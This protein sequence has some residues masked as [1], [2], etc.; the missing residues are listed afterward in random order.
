MATLAAVWERSEAPKAPESPETDVPEAPK[1]PETASKASAAAEAAKSEEKSEED[2]K[3]LVEWLQQNSEGEWRVYDSFHRL[4]VNASRTSVLLAA[5]VDAIS[6]A[7]ERR[8]PLFFVSI[9]KDGF[10]GGFRDCWNAT[11]KD[12]GLKL[13]RAPDSSEV[14]LCEEQLAGSK[15]DL[16]ASMRSPEDDTM[17]LGGFIAAFTPMVELEDHV[18]LDL[19]SWFFSFS[20]L[21]TGGGHG[22]PVPDNPSVCQPRAQDAWEQRVE[23]ADRKLFAHVEHAKCVSCC[24]ALRHQHGGYQH[25]QSGHQRTH[26]LHMASPQVP[27]RAQMVGPTEDE[28]GRQRRMGKG[29]GSGGGSSVGTKLLK[30]LG[31]PENFVLKFCSQSGMAPLKGIGPPTLSQFFGGPPPDLTQYFSVCFAELPPRPMPPRRWDRR[32][33]Y[34]TT[35]VAV[36]GTDRVTQTQQAVNRWYLERRNN[37]IAFHVDPSI[38]TAFHAHIKEATE[39]WNTAFNAAGRGKKVVRCLC[40]GDPD[41]PEDYNPGDTRF[42]P[43]VM[44]ETFVLGYGPSIVDFRSGEILHAAIV[45]GFSTFVSSASTFEKEALVG[46]KGGG[47]TD[48]GGLLSAFHPNVM[49]N[50]RKTVCHEVGHALG[51]RHNFIGAQDGNSS[52]MDYEDMWDTTVEGQPAFGAHFLVEPGKYDVYAIKYG[53]TAIREEWNP[54]MD[55]PASSWADG[56]RSLALLANGQDVPHLRAGEDPRSVDDVNDRELSG[57]ANPLFATDE[58]VSLDGGDPRVTRWEAPGAPW[59]AGT[60]KIS[61]AIRERKRLLEMLTSGALKGGHGPRGDG[62]PGVYAYMVHR[63]L[64]TAVH[65]VV[66]SANVLGGAMLDASREVARPVGR[67]VHERLLSSCVEVLVGSLLRFSDAEA[68]RLLEMV[69]Q[70][71]YALAPINSLA[72]HSAVCRRVLRTVTAS[73]YLARLEDQRAVHAGGKLMDTCDLLS[74]LAFGASQSG[75]NALLYPFALPGG[76]DEPSPEAVTRAGEDAIRA[77]ARLE[78]AK[79]VCGLASSQNESPQVAAS[80]RAFIELVFRSI[81]GDEHLQLATKL[82]EV[83]QMIFPRGAKNL[84]KPLLQ[85]SPRARAA[86]VS[87]E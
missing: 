21:A 56:C 11:P 41:W 27:L 31:F 82:Q 63:L 83:D 79:A 35:P 58:C 14:W 54:D 59:R 78:F 2:P 42:N 40:P 46:T 4:F 13:R 60:D 69:H 47:F 84:P 30:V 33:G 6:V 9:S 32:V 50:V 76:A 7:G 17:P 62:S 3:T 45:L 26:H 5:H 44:T 34:F 66:V 61:Y 57:P 18:L 20:A 51:L 86:W 70:G 49:L 24:S 65:A 77:Q 36:N 15:T 39:S 80:A 29:F 12:V 81:L 71:A 75:T 72:L 38:P 52:V 55:G 28:A 22:M 19:T 73:S 64:G 67:S 10:E 25:G 16:A 1:E 85:A 37:R 23:E 53:Y 87:L 48:E 8:N 74:G 68:E 43:I